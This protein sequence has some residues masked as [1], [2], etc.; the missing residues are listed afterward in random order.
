M[1]KGLGHATGDFII[2]M[3]TD[4]YYYGPTAI[5]RLVTGL[6]DQRV[7]IISGK[8]LTLPEDPSGTPSIGKTFLDRFVYRM[9]FCFNALMMRRTL[10][11]THGRFD[12][13]YTIT[14]DYD[15]LYRVMRTKPK[16]GL[17]DDIVIMYRTSGIS[18]T[19][20]TG[21]GH[22][23]ETINILRKNLQL[24]LS[25]SEYTMINK[26]YANLSLYL[27]VKRQLKDPQLRTLLL[28]RFDF[29]YKISF[30]TAPNLNRPSISSKEN[31]Y[32][33][34]RPDAKLLKYG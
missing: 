11:D 29:P 25:D 5:S 17:I 10:F 30:F 19:D 15:F 12:H 7:D 18:S 22:R 26:G 1:N 27:K 20:Q 16:L 28:K 24:D 9:S 4:D 14:A 2:Y 6:E 32:A 33:S 34:S 8:M 23:E 31:R 21:T 13:R 3:N